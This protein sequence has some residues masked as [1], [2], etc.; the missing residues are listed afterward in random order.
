M[1]ANLARHAFRW[2]LLL[3]DARKLEKLTPPKP[4]PRM[5]GNPKESYLAAGILHLAANNSDHATERNLVGYNKPD[6]FKGQLWAQ[7]LKNRTGLTAEQWGTAAE[8]LRKYRGQLLRA[9]LGEM[10]E[11]R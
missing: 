11:A 8:V 3:I 5:P 1:P 4:Q 10:P 2:S 7:L 6:S 9:G